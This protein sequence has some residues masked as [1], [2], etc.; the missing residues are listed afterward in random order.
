MIPIW[1]KSKK[2]VKEED[3]NA[4]YKD[5]YHDYEDPARVI[6]SSVEGMTSYKSLMFIPNHAAYDY[7]TKEYEKGSR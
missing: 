4:F 7:Y 6:T 1:K 5:T 3:Y 2:D